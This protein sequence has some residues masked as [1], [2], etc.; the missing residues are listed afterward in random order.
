MSGCAPT[1]P[2]RPRSE[3]VFGVRL[4]VIRARA[5]CAST[6]VVEFDHA[7]ELD[8][9]EQS[10]TIGIGRMIGCKRG[11][12]G[13]RRIGIETVFRCGIKPLRTGAHGVIAHVVEFDHAREL[14]KTDPAAGVRV[15]A[16]ARRTH[17]KHERVRLR[18][19][20]QRGTTEDQV[21][22]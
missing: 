3:T 4:E 2:S 19:Q 14:D 1:E 17:H 11:G 12:A 6:D 16:V 20:S 13:P 9:S 5:G 10:V 8:E 22:Q 21:D 18:E 7:G 15:G